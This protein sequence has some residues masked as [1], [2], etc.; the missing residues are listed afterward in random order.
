[1]A[2]QKAA[3][4]EAVPF[5]PTEEPAPRVTETVTPIPAAEEGQRP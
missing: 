1:M 5:T 4:A 2:K 3:A